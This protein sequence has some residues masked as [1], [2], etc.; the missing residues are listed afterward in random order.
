MIT[1][2]N[3]FC[4]LP[5][6]V[7]FI[8]TAHE[9]MRDIMT[10]TAMFISEEEP[11][12]AVSVADHHLTEKLIRQSGKFTLVI[13]GEGQ[14]KLSIQVGSVK[15]DKTDKFEK[16]LIA[17]IPTNPGGAPIPEGAC[18]WMACDVVQE[19]GIKGYTLFVGKVVD[20]QEMG[21]APLIWQKNA[22][23]RLNP[24]S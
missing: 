7:V 10:A 8:C 22:F 3:V 16:F 14:R 4:W 21:V 20:Q 12:L 17:T 18:A 5:C 23:F 24:A 11:L 9:K 2:D 15:G 6:S 13:A 19:H 1:N